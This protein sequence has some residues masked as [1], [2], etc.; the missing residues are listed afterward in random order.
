M[1]MG[2]KSL[3]LVNLH[4]LLIDVL[5]LSTVTLLKNFSAIEGLPLLSLSGVVVSFSN[6]IVLCVG[7]G[8]AFLVCASKIRRYVKV[9]SVRARNLSWRCYSFCLACIVIFFFVGCCWGLV[10]CFLVRFWFGFAL[11]VE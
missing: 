8:V 3:V 9:F 6:M 7:V 2:S 10:F 1:T 4:L 5:D 11:F